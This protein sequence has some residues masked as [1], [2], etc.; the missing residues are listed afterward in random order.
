MKKPCNMCPNDNWVCDNCIYYPSRGG[1]G[2]FNA[3]VRQI[4]RVA[5]EF[6]YKECEKGNNLQKALDNFFA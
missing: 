6:G 3:V 2:Q 4:L 5:V 1:S